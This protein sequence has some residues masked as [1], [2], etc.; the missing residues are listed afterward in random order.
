MRRFFSILLLLV[1]TFFTYA[2]EFTW[3]SVNNQGMGFVTGMV[4]HPDTKKAPDLIYIRTDVGGAYRFDPANQKWIQLMDFASSSQMGF[5][6]VESVAIDPNNADKVYMAVDGSKGSSG[7]ILVSSDR[8]STWQSTGMISNKIYISANDS[9]RGSSGERLMVDPNNS[10]ILYFASR[11]DGLWKKE[12]PNAWVKVGGGLPEAITNPGFT[13][14]L[15]DPNSL[16]GQQSKTIYTGCYDSGVWKSDD[17][18]ISWVN[19]NSSINC[20]RASLATDSTLYV[21][22]GED[23]GD[24]NGPGKV[25][26]YKNGLWTSITP[27]TGTG[28]SYSGITTDPVNPNVVVVTTNQRS[29][30]YSVNKGSSWIR[31]SSKFTY[32][33]SYYNTGESSFNWGTAALVIDPNNTKRLWSTNGYGVIKTDNYTLPTSSWTTVMNNLEELCVMAISTPPL[34]GGAD[35]F[36]VGMDM[37]GMR[38]ASRDIVPTK[39]IAT[40]PYVARGTSIEYC[41]TK[42]NHIVFLGYDQT[43]ET[44]SYYGY[45]TDNGLT[46]SKF[47]ISPG[48]GGKLVISATNEKNWV[49]TPDGITVQPQYT[50]DAGQTWTPCKGITGATH[51]SAW[52]SM[53]FLAADKV[54]GSKFYYTHSGKLF[55]SEDGGANWTT[56]STGLPYWPD[57]MFIKT[58][59]YREGEVWYAQMPYGANPTTRIF[60]SKDGGKKFT[61]LT[62][63]YYA[64]NIAFGKGDNDSIPF[65]YMSGKL[66]KDGPEGIFKSEDEGKTWT[67]ITDPKQLQVA[68]ILE[69]DMRYKNLV[70]TGRV[71]CRGVTYGM[72]DPT[73]GVNNS[74]L[75]TEPNIKIFPNP[76]NEYLTVESV[77]KIISLTL[78]NLV[79]QPLKNICVND[80][81]ARFSIAELVPG[82]YMVQAETRKDT[83]I[84]KIMKNE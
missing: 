13:F 44:T 55:Y 72:A 34:A 9:W 16:K 45:S 21:T 6:Q 51:L 61:T 50:L 62:N 30:Y 32:Y 19:I 73:V 43:N 75:N 83:Q 84:L 23:E 24:Y 64:N 46:W 33:P 10:G 25:A 59:P 28:A 78:T 48:K 8:G 4:I 70:Y 82:C 81:S 74:A 26:K 3:K 12:E 68:I 77:E 7:D 29:M 52:G 57:K 36:T 60:V 71:G 63:L 79:G 2:Q 65:V 14:V 11:K 42:P 31:I 18:G 41:Q 35:L 38:N 69:G 76:T 5:M 1:A 47:N 56:G 15:F 67:L 22:Y 53:T 17:A 58:H 80:Y 39:K 40:F 27:P 54:N 37:V 49:W 66:V 20:L